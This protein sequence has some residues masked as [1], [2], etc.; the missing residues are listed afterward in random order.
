MCNNCII[1][2]I[3][4]IIYN[5]N[6]VPWIF[7]SLSPFFIY[8]SYFIY[9]AFNECCHPGLK[10]YFVSHRIRDRGNI[11]FINYSSDLLRVRGSF[12]YRNDSMSIYKG[13]WNLYN[14]QKYSHCVFDSKRMCFGQKQVVLFIN[15]IVYYKECCHL[16][17]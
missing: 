9:F 14:A 2:T 13:C 17:N 15:N 12:W 10:L 11:F 1:N 3:K 5:R 8:L 16:C 7:K 4:S 6:I